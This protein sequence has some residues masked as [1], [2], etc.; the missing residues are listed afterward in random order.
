MDIGAAMF[1]VVFMLIF[2]AAVMAGSARGY[3]PLEMAVW[4]CAFAIV[5]ALL[6]GV[7]TLVY[8]PVFSAAGEGPPDL[9]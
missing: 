3:E 9:R 7:L 2:C 1:G 8:G 6:N 4:A 5:V